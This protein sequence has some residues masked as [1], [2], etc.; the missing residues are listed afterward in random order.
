VYEGE[1]RFSAAR[2]DGFSV[3]QQQ[4]LEVQVQ[5][6]TVGSRRPAFVSS[7]SSMNRSGT[8]VSPLWPGQRTTPSAHASAPFASM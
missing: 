1:Q 4:E 2:N 6:A 5:E 8:K 7:G 3:R